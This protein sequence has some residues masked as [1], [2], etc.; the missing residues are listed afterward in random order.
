MNSVN[1]RNRIPLNEDHEFV[2]VISSEER[3]STTPDE[4]LPKVGYIGIAEFHRADV[5]GGWCG[6]YVYWSGPEARH[7]LVS[8]DPLTIAPSLLCPTCGSHGF[9]RDGSWVPA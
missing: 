8:F 4:C 2:W 6:G 9:I 3:E 7:D 5:T 1:E